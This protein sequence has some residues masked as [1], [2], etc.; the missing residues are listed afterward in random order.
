MSRGSLPPLED[1]FSRALL[2]SAEADGPS[3]AAYA[4]VA[5][6]L[7][8][9]VG[10]GVGASLPAPAAVAAIGAAGAAGAARWSSALGVKFLALGASAALIVGAGALLVQNSHPTEAV[11][12]S[13]LPPAPGVAA[14]AIASPHAAALPQA[15]ASPQAA[16][17]PRSEPHRPGSSP[18]VSAP[19]QSLESASPPTAAFHPSAVRP[20]ARRTAHGGAA[21]ASSSGRASTNSST[22]SSLADQVQSLDRARVALGSGDSSAALREIA[23]YRAA[24]PDGVFLTEASVLEIEALAA[25]GER[26]LARARAADFV[27]AHPDSPQADRLRTLIPTK[28]R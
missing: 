3:N 10:L 13:V 26:S 1:D 2:G 15:G 20:P 12:P 22:S 25:R 14:P 7:G 18:A 24:Y 16:A 5:A 28:K 6:A 21:P 17:S 9:G 11:H 8:V 19:T 4:K 27:E 23:R